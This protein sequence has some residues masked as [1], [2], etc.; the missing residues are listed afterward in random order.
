LF[1]SHLIKA[2]GRAHETHQR[3]DDMFMGVRHAV[4][5]ESKGKQEPWQLYS[6]NRPYCFGGC[7]VANVVPKPKPVIVTPKP[8]LA[9][10]KLFQDRLKNGSLGPKM[11]MIPAGSFRMGDI[12]GGGDS[13]EQ[14]VHRVSVG[15]FAMG[16]YEVTFAEYDKFA[17]ADGR[18]KPDDEGW[19]RDNRPVINVSWHDAVAY[20]EWLSNQ[21]GFEANVF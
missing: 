11:V 1:T 6:L 14:P 15:K 3:V 18:E 21:T 16:V 17:E 13:D 2:L 4:M 7:Q 9:A 10:G 8:L 5:R 12:Q 20:T 19:G